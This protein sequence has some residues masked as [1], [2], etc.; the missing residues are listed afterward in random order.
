MIL[1]ALISNLV[2][3]SPLLPLADPAPWTG[4]TILNC[5]KRKLR[6]GQKPASVCKDMIQHLN[7]D[8][9]AVFPV[10]SFTRELESR[11][12]F[13]LSNYIKTKFSYNVQFVVHPFTGL[14]GAEAGES[15]SRALSARISARG[16]NDP[17]HFKTMSSTPTFASVKES[18]FSEQP[19]AI[20]ESVTG[21]ISQ[22]KGVTKI[23]FDV[24]GKVNTYSTIRKKWLIHSTQLIGGP[25][26]FTFQKNVSYDAMADKLLD[27]LNTAFNIY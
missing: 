16:F 8:G 27:S 11:E 13:E 19:G 12:L 7:D 15:L 18:E 10:Q 20:W 22:S 23:Q 1:S 3:A 2:L 25:L 6:N 14:K 9:V 24:I 17:Q 21:S 26:Q 4:D 5:V